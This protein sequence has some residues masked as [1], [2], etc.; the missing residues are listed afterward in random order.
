[1]KALSQRFY[2][3]TARIEELILLAGCLGDYSVPQQVEDFFEDKEW[4]VLQGCFGA[5]PARI[6]KDVEA[7]DND[8]LLEWLVLGNKFGFLLR[9][10][11]PIM[12]PRDNGASYSWGFYTTHWF[13][14]DTL[15]AALEQGFE[16]VAKQR[17]KEKA[18]AKK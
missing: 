14:G 9:M 15:D 13:Y 16:W 6:K 2:E 7:G 17:E 11:T 1:M 10:A 8:A 12:T 5:I 4:D 3:E 18:K